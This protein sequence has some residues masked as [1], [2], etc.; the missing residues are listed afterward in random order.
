MVA[1]LRTLGIVAHIDAGKTTLTERILFDAGVQRFVGEV[2]EGTATMDWMR[3]EQERGISIV[4]AATRVLWSA[5]ELQIVDT[6]GHVDFTAEVERCLRVLD[7]VVV[8]LDGVRGVE[9]QTQTVWRQADRW[10]C[11]RLVFVNKMDRVG[12]DFAGAVVAL[13]ER[14]D[15]RPVPV[16]IPLF[17]DHGVFAGL[18]DPVR[19]TAQWFK[20]DVP[21]VLQERLEQELRAAR[22]V[23]VEAC[24]DVDEAIMADFVAGNAVASE[25]LLAALRRACIAG[26]LV[27]TLAGAALHGHG[28]DLLLD[29]ICDLLPSPIDRDR[30][31]IE[32][33]FPAADASAPLCALV[34]KVEHVDAEVRNYVRVFTGTL[35]PSMRLACARTGETFAAPELWAMHASH[36]EPVGAAGP[37]AIVVL[38]GTL[39][40]Q[41]GDTLHAPGHARSLPMPSFPPPVVAAVFEPATRDGEE[42]L[43]QALSALLVDDPTMLVERD[44]ETGLPL[45]YGMGEL[46][47]EIIASRVRERL[48]GGLTVSR[49]RVARCATVRGAAEGRA[50]VVAPGAPA[51]WAEAVVEVEPLPDRGA[52]EVD[53]A[54]LGSN[55]V[56][57]AV[58][59]QLRAS[60]HAGGP[61]ATA[62]SGVRIAALSIRSEDGAGAD[63]ALSQHAV[64]VALEKALAVAGI[65]ALEPG[66]DFEVRCPAEH[67]SAVLA[68]LLS[69]GAVMRQV[70]A[71][72]LGALLQ[73]H[74]SLRA[75]LGYA[76]RLRSLTRG[77]GEVQLQPRGLEALPAEP[78][79][80]P[81]N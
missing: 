70:S 7:S 21:A 5:H 59:S 26:T 6:P 4:A 22:D 31:G 14:F 45:V 54:A 64:A 73:G 51:R 3:Q 30:K 49:P 66:V 36:H 57:A 53:V 24:A 46:H 78:P 18:G 10:R 9:S 52:V 62:A 44:E 42:P 33:A 50:T 55:P 2:D 76:T 48:A 32:G 8:V 63:E 27:P 16:V 81:Q 20:G 43:V 71:G 75:F 79:M 60:V 40:V 61:F 17:D 72:Q 29:A 58:E 25:R 11:A 1:H 65:E 68:D 37:G 69:R 34:F 67:R 39:A 28:V 15:C 56:A 80:P 12:A 35:R 19:G 47:L 74:G 23:I 13:A 77:H 38:P 41:T